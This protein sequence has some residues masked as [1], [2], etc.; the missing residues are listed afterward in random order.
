M[1]TRIG[2]LF[3]LGAIVVIA[4]TGIR[5]KLSTSYDR[6]EIEP[7]MEIES[8]MVD[9]AFWNKESI[10]LTPAEEKSLSIEAWMYDDN[11]WQ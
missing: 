7:E 11:Y 10:D 3:L 8:W 1:K 9:E 2:Q 5:A 6:I 4:L